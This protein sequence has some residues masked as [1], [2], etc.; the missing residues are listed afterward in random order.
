MR[1]LVS[2]ST[3]GESDGT[4]P[5][6]MAV[7][8]R[9]LTASATVQF[10]VGGTATAGS[11]YILTPGTLTFAAGE[12]VKLLP[13]TIIANGTPEPVE[14]VIVTL[15]NPTN[16]VLGAPVTHTISISDSNLPVV[17]LSGPAD[18]LENAGTA[19]YTVTR[20]GVTTFPLTVNYT[21]TGTATAPDDYTTPG[22]SVTIPVGAVSA[23]LPVTLTDDATEEA[24]ETLILT[25]SPDAGYG[26]GAVTQATTTIED[27][28]APP[29]LV[30]TSPVRP[31]IA[32]PNGTGLML[33][34]EATR[35]TPSGVVN[36]PVVWSTVSGPGAV[37]FETATNTS[38]AASFTAP[39]TYLLR[40]SA[41]HG[42]A[43]AT[44]EVIVNVGQTL[45]AQDVGTPVVAGTW[46]EADTVPGSRA[47]G[48]VTLTGAGSGLSSS[49][50]SDG[51]QFLAAPRTGNFDLVVRVASFTNPG[52]SG[53]FRFGLMARASSAA[54][55]PYA[56]TMYKGAGTHTYQARL[57]AGTDPYQSDGGTVYP[58]PYYLRL[59]RAGD[60]FSAYYGADGVAWTQRGS[61]Q[62]IPAMGASPLVGLAITSAVPATASSAVFDSANFYLPTN[63]GP[64][65]NAG[66]ALSGGGPWNLDATVT[67]D[68]RPVPASLAPLWLPEGGA[69]FTS[70]S[71]VDT[72]V[73]FDTTGNYRL[74]LTVGD[75]AITTFDDTTVN[76]TSSPIETWRT[77]KF[78]ANAG[79]PAIAGNL[80]DDEKDGAQNLVEYAL[81]LDPFTSSQ[82]QLPTAVMD[83]TTIQ[84]TWRKNKAATDITI[85]VQT[86]TDAVNWTTV[87]PS[88]FIQSDDGQT[89][90]II[91][92]VPRTGN[93]MLI[94]LLVLP[95]A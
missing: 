14:T 34:T 73:T 59:V 26:L 87:T 42:I 62:S 2:A 65:V 61:T 41:T 22:G 79:N 86:S 20:T 8:D 33:V 78:G 56:M 81:N 90:V 6:L 9:P 80:A 50:L 15:T 1:F 4:E 52:A 45:T 37:T 11:D 44:D 18:I 93:R 95:P 85:H 68:A 89:Q 36:L 69:T 94:R 31:E 12:T 29:V 67:D 25:I 13:F 27:D 71:S 82:H 55:A 60:T 21:V 84:L 83:T 32:I 77:A 17:N 91:S 23:P 7:L 35:T 47:G 28:D 46:S 88:N 63:I 43:T 19:N 24:D 49:G 54:N 64:L 70:A 74:R 51:F 57:T 3:R 48:T 75:G 72:A 40:A 10:T 16:S 76:Y 92:T 38:E 66:P 5:L 53:S 30:I 58:M 39:G